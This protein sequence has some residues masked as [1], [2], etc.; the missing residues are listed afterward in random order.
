MQEILPDDSR[1]NQVF[2]GSNVLLFEPERTN[3]DWNFRLFGVPVRVHPMFWLVSALLGG[4]LLEEPDGLKL[5]CLWV[6][7]VFFSILLHEMGHVAVGRIFGARGHIVLYSFG[8]L[9]IGSSALSNRWKRI[10]VYLAGPGVQL[11]LFAAII[12][13][14]LFGRVNLDAVPRMVGET[15]NLLLE[16]NLF[17]ALLNLLPI[18]PLDGGRIARDFLEWLAPANGVRISLGLSMFTAGL[19]AVNALAARAGKP[20]L[21]Y[22]TSGSLYTILFFGMFAL[23]NYQELQQTPRG[24]D[25]YGG[26]SRDPWERDPDYWRDR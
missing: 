23:N 18:W 14:V 4:N 10:A 2:Y 19:I 11:M 16:I 25:R 6:G 20:F 21:P 1:I 22:M 5:L 9:A 17:W 7:C 13:V 26:D 24:P 3:F 8:G 12:A 15:L